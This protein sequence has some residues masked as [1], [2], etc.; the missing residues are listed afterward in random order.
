MGG[1]CKGSRNDVAIDAQF[2]AIAEINKQSEP[3]SNVISEVTSIEGDLAASEATPQV[4]SLQERAI[5]KAA[6]AQQIMFS[7]LS[8]ENT[9]CVID[10]MKMFRLQVGQLVF[11]QG[12][13]AN[14]FYVVTTGQLEVTV[15]SQRTS[16]LNQGHC[17]G[18]QALLQNALRNCSV[19][20]LEA[21][22][23]WGLDRLTFRKVLE[24]AINANYEE[25][26]MFISSVKLFN[27]LTV[28]Q[29]TSLVEALTSL[30]YESGQVIV[31]EGDPGD[32]F[33]LIK[34][35]LVSCTQ[36]GRE[37]RRMSKGEFFGEQALLYDTVR[38]ATV[39]ALTEVK[40]ISISREI[41]MEVLGNR[42]Q[43][44]IYH[45]SIRMALEKS[46]Y[47]GRLNREQI[48]AI[49]S[50]A[51]V[52]H[53]CLGTTLQ[54]EGA[55]YVILKG[56]VQ[57]PSTFKKFDVIGESQMF[58]E[59][60]LMSGEEFTTTSEVD[61]ATLTKTEIETAIDGDFKTV[62]MYNEALSAVN[63]ISLLR[64]LCK[65]KDIIP[66]I[67]VREFTPDSFVFRE[68][69]PSDSLY[70]VKSGVATVSCRG[71]TIRYVNEN[72]IF[73]ERGLLEG[74]PRSCDVKA[75]TPL[76]CWVLE[77]SSFTSV[78][79]EAVLERLREQMQ[80]QD[81]SIELSD[82]VPVRLLGK[83]MFGVVVLAEYR[84][85]FYAV[86]GI[87][88]YKVMKYDIYDC[89]QQE[90]ELLLQI[91]HPFIMKLVKTFKDK[92][93]IYFLTEFV[94]GADM[95]DVIRDIGVLTESAA[96]F[97]CSCLVSALK[98]LHERCIIYR[99]LKPENIIIDAQGYPKLIDFG[100]AKQ[101]RGRTMTLVGTPHY[102]A[103]EVITNQ[104]YGI[105]VDYWALG[106][107]LYELLCGAVPFGE[108]YADPYDIY[109][110]VL[111]GKLNFSLSVP[112]VVKALITQLLSKNPAIRL[113]VAEHLSR[114]PWFSSIVWVSATQHQLE[115]RKL[116][117]PYIPDLKPVS[118]SAEGKTVAQLFEEH[119]VKPQ[120]RRIR[121]GPEGWDAAF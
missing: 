76:T 40:C 11:E 68:G 104:G 83:G 107:I 65:K 43:D 113:G 96:Q 44:I 85:V 67:S 13:V 33:Y 111:E 66:L 100:T 23:L 108:E 84:G 101:I 30:R 27:S 110:K 88:R 94:N 24:S 17:F 5:I 70:I 10:E 6:L 22:E 46:Q 9:E 20:A 26:L 39:T 42:L 2:N 95:F 55:L 18:E 106:V 36:Q 82:L 47:L 62:V 99:D 59:E 92:D 105:A 32:L 25:L 75:L 86:K 12:R 71:R 58:D 31:N 78:V 56:T 93:W 90:R 77:Q 35:G 16:L 7:S 45:N 121:N 120:V 41:L 119:E 74:L 37:L 114:H 8:D 52:K 69:D 81:F 91:E 34:E 97:Y 54:A 3:K 38:T 117:A 79:D 51:E 19:R 60:S 48:E 89:I 103:P 29:K 80:L 64:N 72:S 57:G 49:V 98:Y 1:I 112:P 115:D 116:S 50:I 21:A 63:R 102:M 109:Q 14:H 15:D 61:L 87:S 28:S 53:L 118:K 4:M 73:G